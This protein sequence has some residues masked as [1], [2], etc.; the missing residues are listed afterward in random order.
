[1]KLNFCKRVLFLGGALLLSACASTTHESRHQ[2]VYIQSEPPGATILDRKRKLGTTP[3]LV[4]LRRDK[5]YELELEAN[6]ERQKLN[7]D[8][9][10]RWT[11]SFLMNI[12]L[13]GWAPLGWAVDY[14]TGAAWDFQDPAPLPF[15]GTS[16]STRTPP[17]VVALAPPLA[18][19]FAL[20]DEAAQYW[21]QRLPR[22]YPKA[23]ILPYQ[24]T[25]RTFQELGYEHDTR[26][27]DPQRYR[28]LIHELGVQQVFFSEARPDNTQILLKGERRDLTGA[29]LEAPSEVKLKAETTLSKDFGFESHHQWI[30]IFPNTVGVEFSST[31]TRLGDGTKSYLGY[32]TTDGRHS[33][34]RTSLSYLQALTLARLQTPRMDGLARWKFQFTPAVRFSYKKIFFPE[35]EKLADVN[36]DYV[37]L[38]AGWGPEF[39]WQSGRHYIYV[40]VVPLWTYYQ[41]EWRQPGGE[42]QSMALGTLETNSELGYLFFFNDRMS[43]RTFSKTASTGGQLWNSVSQKIN[44]TTPK[45]TYSGESYFG[46]AIGY[47][48]DVRS[49]MA[50]H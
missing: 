39:G 40:K 6:N 35:F 2:Y 44:P 43:L 12:F 5:A 8:S 15:S 48:F 19:S 47:T 25:L 27:T 49:R 21:E 29:V 50:S 20:S 32:E 31:Q 11:S 36:F 18:E 22:L 4:Y 14:A 9:K 34:L 33:G 23:K 3:A 10:Y 16:V 7:L 26:P 28:K 17:S 37:Q 41:I 38:G 42:A 45:L 1:M 24:S 30:Q 13:G 46:V